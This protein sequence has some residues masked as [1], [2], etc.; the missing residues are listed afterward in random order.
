MDHPPHFNN[1]EKSA[2]KIN[3]S[4]SQVRIELKCDHKSGILYIVPSDSSWVCKDQN[5][6]SHS[7]SGFF[8][9]IIENGDKKTID[10]MQKWGVYYRNNPFM[11]SDE[12]KDN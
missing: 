2:L 10:L 4:E 3:R 12:S 11:D 6:G 9:D 8:S 5:L 7:I 1:L